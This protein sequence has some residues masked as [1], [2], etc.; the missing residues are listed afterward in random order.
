MI[1][2]L[3]LTLFIYYTALDLLMRVHGHFLLRAKVHC[4]TDR[5]LEKSTTTGMRRARQLLHPEARSPSE[6]HSHFQEVRL[7]YLPVIDRRIRFLGIIITAGPL[8]GL[9]GTVGGMLSTFSGIAASRGNQF[10]QVVAGISEA[11]I[12]TQT[13]LVIS[14]PAMVILSMIMQRRN[15]LRRALLRLERYN[16]RQFFKNHPTTERTHKPQSSEA[17][18]GNALPHTKKEAT[19]KLDASEHRHTSS[20]SA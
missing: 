9:L 17:S 13:G 6:I 3:M 4:M 18:A 14:I 1:P 12:T 2:L 16:M 15:T 7:F 10:D 8:L 20:I 5:Q 19:R 11:L